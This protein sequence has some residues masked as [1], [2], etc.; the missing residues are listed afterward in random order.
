MGILAVV[1][2]LVAAVVIAY[3]GQSFGA[4]TYAYE[5]VVVGIGAALGGFVAGTLLGPVSTWGPQFD[6]MYLLPA[7]IGAIVVAIVV[8]YV[9]RMLRSGG[10]S[11]A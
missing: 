6:G 7:A 10:P 2:L 8:E 3:A 1:V 4:S 9:G 11:T 5:W